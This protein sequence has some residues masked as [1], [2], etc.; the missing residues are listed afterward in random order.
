MAATQEQLDQARNV[1]LLALVGG[2]IGYVI[3]RNPALGA[4][5]LIGGATAGGASLMAPDP[6]ARPAIEPDP[7]ARRQH[8]IGA[9]SFGQVVGNIG[10]RVVFQ[11]AGTD[12]NSIVVEGDPVARQLSGTEW[13]FTGPGTVEISWS[14][15]GE[16]RQ[17]IFVVG[18]AQPRPEPNPSPSPMPGLAVGD[19]VIVGANALPNVLATGLVDPAA[20]AL[21]VGVRQLQSNQFFNGELLGFFRQEP[22]TRLNAVRIGQPLPVALVPTSLV[23]AKLTV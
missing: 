1:G 19:E 20:V 21:L 5:A 12:P 9:N 10:D 17:V 6:Q 18:G 3:T 11:L 15:G 23:I 4:V 8:V 22:Y 14:V 13:E 7:P 2:A 16:G